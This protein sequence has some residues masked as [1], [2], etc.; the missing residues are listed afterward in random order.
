MIAERHCNIP[1]M[2]P[3]YYIKPYV[4]NAKEGKMEPVSVEK[5]E[6]FLANL[7]AAELKAMG[8]KEGPMVNEMPAGPEKDVKSKLGKIADDERFNLAVGVY[9]GFVEAYN[10]VKPIPRTSAEVDFA[11]M[12]RE[13]KVGSAEEAVNYFSKRFLR[14]ELQA[15]RRAA[16]VK[17]LAGELKSD[18]LDCSDKKLGEALRKVVHLILSAPK[19]QL[20]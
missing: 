20:G 10:R 6:K 8:S 1:Q 9:S 7:N 17:F 15:E 4:W 3:K 18:K 12:L 16:V 13:A 2:L 11:V 14:V 5:Y 19:Y